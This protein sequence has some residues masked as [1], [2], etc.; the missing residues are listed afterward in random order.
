MSD[1]APVSLITAPR[2]AVAASAL[3]SI[4]VPFWL[5]SADVLQAD[6]PSNRPNTPFDILAM[7]QLAEASSA[8][9]FN[10]DRRPSA[11]EDAVDGNMAAAEAAPPASAPSLVGLIVGRAAPGLALIRG[12]DG[13]TRLLRLGDEAN[14]WRLIA[15]SSTAATFAMGEQVQQIGLDFSNRPESSAAASPSAPTADLS[16]ASG[17]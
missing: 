1:G 9:L 7:D 3:I 6:I 10:A 4:A 2:L 17:Q 11:A 16:S 5:L 13:Q 8:P 15:L 12:D 14:G